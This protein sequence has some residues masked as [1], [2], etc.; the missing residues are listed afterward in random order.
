MNA[1][2]EAVAARVLIEERWTHIAR[3]RGVSFDELAT[4]SGAPIAGG[5]LGRLIAATTLKRRA[6]GYIAR[7]RARLEAAREDERQRRIECAE[8]DVDNADRKLA[9]A[10]G[11]PTAYAAA[12]RAYERAEGR[13]AR[14]EA[15]VHVPIS[16]EMR[17]G[18]EIDVALSLI[19]AMRYVH[20]SERP[21]LA[22]S[23]AIEAP[24]A[25]FAR[26]LSR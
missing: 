21:H 23:L 14:E 8:I 26:R 1:G 25:A 6:R 22:R 18:E 2:R 15:G 9:A 3:E 20:E 5:G 13:L 10:A 4:L 11:D 19:E 17:E 16:R 24:L 7:R 12:L